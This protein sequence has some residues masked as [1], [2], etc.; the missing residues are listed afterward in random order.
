MGATERAALDRLVREFGAEVKIQYDAQRT[1]LHAKAW[2]FRRNT[3]FDTAYVGSSNLSRAAL[4]DGV[5]WNVRLSGSA[6]RLCSRSSERP[7]TRTGTTPRS[8]PTT[9]TVIVTGWTTRW[10]R[11]RAHD[12]RPSHDL[13]RR[14]RGAA[15]SLPAGDAGGPRGRTVGAWP[16]PQ[17]GRR[18]HRHRQDG[19]RGPGLPRLCASRRRATI[20]ALHCTPPGDPRTVAAHLPGGPRDA[21]F[22]ELYVGGARPERWQH[23][24]ASVQSLDVVRHR[25]TSRRTPTTS[26]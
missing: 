21:D 14:P 22:G 4:L 5:E 16:A 3:A 13:A 8:R 1:R 19:D 24:F 25:P 15:V 23:V 9:R 18:S 2:M 26:S 6:H 20:A 10:P 17:S 12:S 11:P 7:S